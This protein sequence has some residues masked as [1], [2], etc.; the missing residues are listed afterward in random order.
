[1]VLLEAVVLLRPERAQGYFDLARARAF[2]GEKKRALA[3]LQQAL[4]AGFKDR[5]RI[6]GEKAFEKWRGDPELAALLAG[7][8]L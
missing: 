5:A 1:M 2:L 3:A 7:L 6:E 8:A 4:A